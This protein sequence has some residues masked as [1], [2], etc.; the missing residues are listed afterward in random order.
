MDSVRHTRVS[1]AQA[2]QEELA[3][4]ARGHRS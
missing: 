3:R 2:V 4:D 1:Y